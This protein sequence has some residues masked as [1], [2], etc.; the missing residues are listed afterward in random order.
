MRLRRMFGRIPPERLTSGGGGGDDAATIYTYFTSSSRQDTFKADVSGLATQSSVDTIDANVDA[1]LVDT[2][3]LQ[4]NQ[5]NWLTATGFSTFDYT[6]DKVTVQAIDNNV[7]TSSVIAT[8]ALNNSAFTTGFYNSIN[9]EVDT[10]LADYDAPTKAELDTA[11]S[12]IIA[13]MPDVSGLSTFDPNSDLVD[14]NIKYVN[15]IEVIGNGEDGT[16]WNPI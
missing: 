1:I 16:P 6:T 12:N 15:D 10:A 7:I 5:G 11:E 13:A 2:N 3:E 4:T 14:A 8:N 9:A